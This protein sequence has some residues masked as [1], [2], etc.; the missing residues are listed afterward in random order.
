MVHEIW[1]VGAAAAQEPLTRE[2]FGNISGRERVVFYTLALI[3]LVVFGR[4]LLRRVRLW[5]LG[6]SSPGVSWSDLL[7]GAGRL[8]REGILQR[9]VLGRGLA[10]LAHVLLFSGFLVLLVGTT[11]IAIEHVL[12]DLLGRA[13][14]D[15]VFHRGIYFVVYEVVLDTAGVAFIV[16]CLLFM[17]RRLR[18]P[19]SLAHG[20]L[21]WVVLLSFLGIAATGYLVEGLRILREATP[22]PGFSFVGLGVARVLEAL[23]TSRAA[24]VALHRGLWWAHAVLS[25]GIVAAFPYTR[26][27]HAL[28][29][30]IRLAGPRARLGCLTPVS[31]EEVEET[32]RVGAGSVSHFSRRQLLELD[33]CVS[34]G[35]CEE[36]CPAFE[37]GKPLSPRGVVQGLRGHLERVGPA[38]LRKKHAGGEALPGD[39]DEAADGGPALHGET[40]LAETLWSCTTCAACVDVCPLGVR[41]LGHITD[42]RRHLVGEGDLR[43]A[44]ARALQK[45][46]RSGNPWGMP[47]GERL[48]WAEGLD[49][50]TVE[51]QPDFEV[52]YW[53]GCAASYDR[54]IRKVARSMVRLLRVAGVRFAVL[55]PE[56]RCTGESARRMGEEFVFQEL[57]TH[58]VGALERHGVRR[59]VTHC[60]HCLNSLLQ[61]YPQ[62][63]GHWDV[64]HHTVFLAELVDAGRLPRPAVSANRV[65][66]HDPCYL[67]R[68]HGQTVAPRRLLDSGAIIEMPRNGRHTACCGGGGGRM[69]FDDAPEERI[70]RS[71]VREAVGTGADTV[72]VAC[73]FCLIM[74][75]D[76]AA[77]V[78]SE[79]EV[80]D[81]AEILAE[82]LD[83]PVDG[84]DTSRDS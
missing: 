72:A 26:L 79:I 30:S 73:P 17:K 50:P 27:L 34:C 84:G 19:P 55:G 70:G 83:R 46:Q 64:V 1:P 60:P 63:G 20:L 53:V 61:D 14:D 47:S 37:A 48:D 81:V 58:N 65:T 9:G 78:G 5:R 23:G 3:A 25:L 32:G 52:L 24:S 22:R 56:E 67:A 49:V 18:P 71:R 57:A 13:P 11:L 38:L 16:G 51:R 39:G 15:P 66:Y 33:A 68:V 69:W 77:A 59:I 35:R 8:V 42:M 40:I 54:R 4:G 43:G 75:R 82:A 80:R 74:I 44:P 62:F 2:I 6:Q 29:G 12:A 21:D 10:S 76:G 45:M 36:A 7:A 31:I 41:P 28:A